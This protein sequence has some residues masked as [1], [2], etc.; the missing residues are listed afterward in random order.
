MAANPYETY[1]RTAVSTAPPAQLQ[2]MLYD[3]CIRFAR[4][5]VQ[6]LESGELDK[7]SYWTARSQDILAEWLGT[8]DPR[9]GDMA[10]NLASIYEYLYHRLA[11]G[12]IQRDQAAY[13]EVIARLSDLREAW[14]QL[15]GGAQAAAADQSLAPASGVASV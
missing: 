3:G 1:R 11:T 9:A 13:G 8:L 2:V 15:A 12:L 5:A 10:R 14:M 6:H 7:A 4:T